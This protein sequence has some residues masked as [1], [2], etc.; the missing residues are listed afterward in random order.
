[1]YYFNVTTRLT[2][3][4]ENRKGMYVSESE[5]RLG[6]FS[7]KADWTLELHVS[8]NSWEFCCKWWRFSRM[9]IALCE[10]GNWRKRLTFCLLTNVAEQAANGHLSK[11][12][13]RSQDLISSPG[14]KKAIWKDNE[15]LCRDCL[16]RIL[17]PSTRNKLEK[18]KKNFPWEFKN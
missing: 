15:M 2:I 4:I 16:H 12:D 14:Y 7:V 18:K 11:R 5:N 10:D 13:T 6:V 1:M 8:H 9:V 17:Y 3:R